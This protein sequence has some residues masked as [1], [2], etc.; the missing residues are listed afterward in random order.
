MEY[1][2]FVI[3][4]I[5]WGAILEFIIKGS[6]KTKVRLK[7]DEV[8]IKLLS[9]IAEKHGVSEEEINAIVLPPTK[10]R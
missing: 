7:N 10:K 5:I 3:G 6:T 9:K 4:I 1:L 8:I 2:I